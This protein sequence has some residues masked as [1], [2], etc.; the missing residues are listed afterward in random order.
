[1]RM[2]HYE[3]AQLVMENRWKFMHSSMACIQSTLHKLVPM[4][5]HTTTTNHL[6][7]EHEYDA[8]DN[9]DENFTT[10]IK[11]NNNAQPPPWQSSPNIASK[12]F[13][14]LTSSYHLSCNVLIQ[15]AEYYC[16]L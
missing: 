15:Y 13:G 16:M 11:G 9:G 12:L 2:N 3:G 1:M 7:A 5:K 4:I 6:V 8:R 14:M 10:S